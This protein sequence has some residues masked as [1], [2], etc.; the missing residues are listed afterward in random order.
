[1]GTPTHQNRVAY[2][3]PPTKTH[4]GQNQDVLGCRWSNIAP[5]N[6]SLHKKRRLIPCFC[7]AS[8]LIEN[9]SDLCQ[10]QLD[11]IRGGSSHHLTGTDEETA[12]DPFWH[13]IHGRPQPSLD[14][15]STERVEQPSPE[16]QLE[17]CQR[18]RNGLMQA[19]R[20]T[21]RPDHVV[22]RLNGTNSQARAIVGLLPSGFQSHPLTPLHSKLDEFS[23]GAT[24]VNL[25]SSP[26]YHQ[27]PHALAHGSQYGVS[28]ADTPGSL[29]STA[30][31]V[32]LAHDSD[33]EEWS[34]DSSLEH[35]KAE[36]LCQHPFEDESDLS[37]A[38]TSLENA[39]LRPDGD[40]KGCEGEEGPL[41]SGEGAEGTPARE[42][43]QTEAHDTQPEG[44]PAT[45]DETESIAPVGQTTRKVEKENLSQKSDL[46]GKAS[47]P[48]K[49]LLS[50][51]P[52]N[53]LKLTADRVIYDSQ[54]TTDHARVRLSVKR[55]EESAFPD[56]IKRVKL[57]VEPKPKKRD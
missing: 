3:S 13:I 25:F 55:K 50:T 43:S 51:F 32:A 19:P 15:E 18:F 57:F 10:V 4:L 23:D 20:P 16:M 29:F 28:K 30:S 12:G 14:G 42:T 21:E 9:L 46:K 22:A 37:K 39:F 26:S 17:T 49:K 56:F 27:S 35:A 38:S 11:Q 41:D 36:Y 31:I 44:A 47:S 52:K 34:L 53:T 8:P 33:E 1:M 2:R 7:E 5:I 40:I 48:L 45:K 6:V 54:K 24:E